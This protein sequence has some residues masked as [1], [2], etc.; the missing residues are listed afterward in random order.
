MKHALAVLAVAAA[1]W[2]TAFAAED[3]M[4]G[5][6]DNTLF[7]TVP[8]QGTM[9]WH[10]YPDHSY[11]A[12]MENGDIEIGNWLVVGGQICEGPEGKAQR[13]NGLAGAKKPGDSWTDG[14]VKLELKEGTQ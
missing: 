5:F 7:V 8:E 12:T 1:S 2:G 13:C 4:A 3:V 14:P 11:S 9:R 10:Y 6:Y